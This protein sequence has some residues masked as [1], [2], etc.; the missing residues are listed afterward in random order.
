M[1]CYVGLDASKKHTSVCVVD[2]GGDLLL[3][4]VV[5]SHPRAIIEFLRG[6]RLRFARIGIEAWGLA[7]W[8]CEGLQRAALPAVCIET[9][10][11]HALLKTQRNK[12]DRTDARGIA[13]LMRTGTYRVVHLKSQTSQQALA[14]LTVRD[15]LKKKARDLGNAVRGLLLGFGLKLDPRRPVTFDHR[16]RLLTKNTFARD[17][18]TPLLEM[19]QLLLER[20]N[21]VER[22]LAGIANEDPVCQLLM[23]APGIGPI[24]AVL[25]RST[26]DDPHR[27]SRSRNVGP[28]LGLTP[29]TYQS[30]ET[31]RR[32]RI[33]RHGSKNLRSALYLSAL[34]VMR[35][36]SR[37]SWLKE[38]GSQIKARR[39]HRRA[40]VAVA[41]RLAV[42]LHQMWLAGEPFR[43][44]PGPGQKV[45]NIAVGRLRPTKE[46]MSL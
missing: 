39:G 29:R 18:V 32:G 10:Q 17:V 44:E 41:R 7:Y 1:P 38:W 27:F 33:T 23:T 34:F 45:E 3:E 20:A 2:A 16:V 5:E 30:G 36:K 13:N 9:R 14:L 6:K 43:W 37:S 28:H 11:A 21:I 12:T 42:T 26:I 31:E 19:R 24:T 15:L 8:I 35:E 4:G 46:S 22:Q 40:V 25:Y